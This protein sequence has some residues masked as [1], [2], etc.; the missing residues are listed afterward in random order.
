MLE[1][2]QYRH[3]R[4]LR[5][6]PRRLTYQAPQQSVKLLHRLGL[7]LTCKPRTTD[8]LYRPFL[9]VRSH[10]LSVCHRCG[11]AIRALQKLWPMLSRRPPNR[12]QHLNLLHRHH[13]PYRS[14]L[15]QHYWPPVL[16]PR[17]RS[18]RRKAHHRPTPASLRPRRHRALYM[19]SHCHKLVF[20]S[21]MILHTG[22]GH[23]MEGLM[24]CE[25]YLPPRIGSCNRRPAWSA[26]LH[27]H[28]ASRTIDRTKVHPPTPT[29]RRAEHLRMASKLSCRLREEAPS[30]LRPYLQMSTCR[31]MGNHSMRQRMKMKTLRRATRWS[32]R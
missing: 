12:Q 4:R 30:S 31:H 8:S 17:I 10:H 3:S 5:S 9:V 18:N 6:S 28:M 26:I 7:R 15:A 14:D 21:M 16:Q 27:R 1:R 19:K 23:R 29:H 20:P 11:H 25:L 13:H 32:R 22:I 24:P 2:C